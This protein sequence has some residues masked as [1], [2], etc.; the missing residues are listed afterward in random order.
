L[1]DKTGVLV[2]YALKEI[3]KHRKPEKLWTYKEK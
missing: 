2:A 3:F 1:K